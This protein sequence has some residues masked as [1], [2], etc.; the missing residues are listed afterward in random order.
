MQS[1]CI[2]CTK[3]WDQPSFYFSWVPVLGKHTKLPVPRFRR[4]C[5][6]NQPLGNLGLNCLS[7]TISKQDFFVLSVF[8]VTAATTVYRHAR[9]SEFFRQSRPPVHSNQSVLASRGHHQ[10]Q[11]P[12]AIDHIAPVFLLRCH[13]ND[14]LD[15]Y[16]VPPAVEDA[17]LNEFE[18]DC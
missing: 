17:N 15:A 4:R 6:H 13:I 11:P 12:R 18:K 7:A 14:S 5:G 10:Y 3:I 8:R 16:R 1:R 9:E 2:R